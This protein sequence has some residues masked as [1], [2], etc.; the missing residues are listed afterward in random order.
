MNPAAAAYSDG[1]LCVLCNARHSSGRPFSHRNAQAEDHT[2]DPAQTN[3]LALSSALPL[4]RPLPAT[5]ISVLGAR[6]RLSVSLLSVPA[7]FL[8]A[9]LHGQ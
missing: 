7:A 2:L 1:R 6:R 8:S 5:S 4:R 3:S 9:G